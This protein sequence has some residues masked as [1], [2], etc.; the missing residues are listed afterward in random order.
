M[1]DANGCVFLENNQIPYISLLSLLPVILPPAATT[2]S[3]V[4]TIAL[5]TV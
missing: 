1:G 5:L 2:Y 4:F 3:Q